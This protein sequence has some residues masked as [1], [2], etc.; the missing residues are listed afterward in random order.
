MIFLLARE[1]SGTLNPCKHPA[2]EALYSSAKYVLGSYST[3]ALSFQ[4]TFA[5]LLLIK[6]GQRVQLL[7]PRDRNSLIMELNIETVIPQVFKHD[8]R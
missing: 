2:T 4:C 8:Y 7:L 1:H 6:C 5:C 3:D